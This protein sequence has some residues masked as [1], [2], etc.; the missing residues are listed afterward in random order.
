[1]TFSR[2]EIL[3]YKLDISKRKTMHTTPSAIHRSL[4]DFGSAGGTLLAF[5]AFSAALGD[6]TASF[7]GFGSSAASST[8][9]SMT[10]LICA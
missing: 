5:F 4:S 6:F 2:T 8:T 7:G 3:L 1:M 9:S 10:L